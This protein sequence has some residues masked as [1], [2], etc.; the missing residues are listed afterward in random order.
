MNTKELVQAKRDEIKSRH[1]N[2]EVLVKEDSK[3]MRVLAKLV[4]LFNREFLTRYATTINGKI[5]LPRDLHYTRFELELLD[6]EEEH[7]NQEEK[8]TRPLFYFLYLFVLP[9]VLSM[10]AYF[11]YKV[12]L[13]SIDIK[14]ELYGYEY[15]KMTVIPAIVK[16]FTGPGYLFMFP[17]GSFVERKM[18]QYLDKKHRG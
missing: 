3:F 17:F 12:Y 14:Y 8:Y 9:S 6:H 4:W 10:C 5:Y 16:N 2:F 15:V 18:V 1:K 11:E 13:R 7:I